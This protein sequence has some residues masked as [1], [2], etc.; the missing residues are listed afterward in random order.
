MNGLIIGKFHPPHLGHKYL[1]DFANSYCSGYTDVIVFGMEREEIPTYHRFAALEDHYYGKGVKFHH[2]VETLPQYPEEHPDFWNIWREKITGHVQVNSDTILFASENYGAKLAEVLGCKFM[3]V[4]IDREIY[5]I[6]GSILREKY[7]LEE[8]FDYL[9]P[10]VKPFLTKKVVIFGSDSVGKTTL[11]KDVARLLGG[12]FVPEYARTYLNTF[13]AETI[14]KEILNDIGLGQISAQVADHRNPQKYLTIFDTDFLT[15]YG[16]W[17][18]FGAEK[19]IEFENL[20][21][22]Q[23]LYS[24]RYHY[25]VPD[26]NIPFVADPQRYGG[27]KR[28]SDTQFW[29]DILE[30]FG[31]PYTILSESDRGDR[32]DHAVEII[33]NIQV[34]NKNKNAT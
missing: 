34:I 25:I 28:Q 18:L 20:L 22:R 19:D 24:K 29:I 8:Y 10:E 7:G 21:T 23:I 6:S 9:L 11:A 1:I 12:K 14:T 2:H 17:E 15:T 31:K 33:R 32:I 5:S 16:Y 30:K 4:D 3:P 27:D 26:T 13:P